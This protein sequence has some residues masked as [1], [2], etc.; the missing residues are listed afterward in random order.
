MGCNCKNVEKLN[1]YQPFLAKNEKKGVMNR[2]NNFS[3]N[4]LNK[5]II[6][7]LFIILTPIVI[8]A[9]IFNYLFKDKLTLILPKFMGK[10]LKRI[11][12]NE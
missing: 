6:I 12:E 1:K 11:K 8:I 10:Y 5:A 9:L 4:V 7:L 2:I 3:I